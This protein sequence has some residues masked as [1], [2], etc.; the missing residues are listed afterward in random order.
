MCPTTNNP[1]NSSFQSFNLSITE[2]DTTSIHNEDRKVFQ[3][4]KNTKIYFV[5]FEEL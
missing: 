4:R 3:I 1:H 5:A 2:K